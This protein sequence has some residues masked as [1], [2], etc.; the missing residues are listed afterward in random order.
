M[1]QVYADKTKITNALSTR[2]HKMALRVGNRQAFIDRAKIDFRLGEK[3]NLAK[4]KSIKIP[5]LLIWGAKDTWIPRK[6]KTYEQHFTQ[7]KISRFRKF[8]S[9]AYGRKSERKL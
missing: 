1:E 8:W 3:E 4:L 7:C 5:T 9:C 6:W 2:Y